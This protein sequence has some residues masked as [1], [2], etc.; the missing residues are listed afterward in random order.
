MGTE[1]RGEQETR[2]PKSM[3]TEGYENRGTWEPK[4]MGTGAAGTE[5]M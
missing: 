2:E 4:G 3:G 1:E 5:G